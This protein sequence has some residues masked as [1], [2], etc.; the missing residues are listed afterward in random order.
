MNLASFRQLFS[1]DKPLLEVLY[2]YSRDNR[3]CFDDL[4]DEVL[5]D[6]MKNKG[7]PI[8]FHEDLRQST[9]LIAAKDP[10]DNAHNGERLPKK[11]RA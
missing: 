3:T 10:V 11:P 9:K 8:T 5:R 6:L 4:Y 1:I 7:Q 2:E